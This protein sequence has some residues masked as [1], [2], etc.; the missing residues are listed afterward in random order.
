MPRLV[1]GEGSS[2]SK[3]EREVKEG[4]TVAKATAKKLREG[5]EAYFA[6][7]SRMTEVLE[8]VPTGEKDKYGRDICEERVALNG[9]GE[10]VKVEK[11]LV[12]PSITDLQNHL[13]LTAA[14]W[15]QMKEDE[16]AKA[17]IE[18]AEMRVERYLRRELLT[19][20]GK[21]LKG[22]I[23]TLQRDFGFD[24]EADEMGGTLE[25]LLGGGED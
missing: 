4:D 23:L 8:S 22:V 19:R 20:P 3:R 18:A 25:E 2:E 9:R 7:I 14:Q 15:E 6:G 11:W 5:I 16:G 10:V 17:V 1:C 12:P 13:E 24:A 21:D